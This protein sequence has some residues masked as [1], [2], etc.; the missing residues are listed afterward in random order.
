M[1]VV[2][3]A[4]N[5]PENLIPEVKRQVWSLDNQISLNH[6]ESMDQL[7]GLSLAER[8][9]STLLLGLF[10]VLSIVLA[11]AGIYGVMSY[12]IH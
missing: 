1:S 10:A 5:H 9:F 3:R 12:G 2:L 11:A 8:R 6:I 4:P 7:L